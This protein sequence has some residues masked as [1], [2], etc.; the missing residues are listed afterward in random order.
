LAGGIVSLWKTEVSRHA[1][2]R[3]R[4]IRQRAGLSVSNSRKPRFKLKVV[5]GELL[6]LIDREY[7]FVYTHNLGVQSGTAVI[8]DLQ[9]RR[10]FALCNRVLFFITEYPECADSLAIACRRLDRI[11]RN[12]LLSIFDLFEL[13]E[14][15][16][17]IQLYNNVISK[18]NVELSSTSDTA[19]AQLATPNQK[20]RWDGLREAML[21]D[22]KQPFIETVGRNGTSRNSTT[23]H[24]DLSTGDLTQE[25][26]EMRFQAMRD[27]QHPFIAIADSLLLVRPTHSVSTKYEDEVFVRRICLVS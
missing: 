2:S 8:E 7:K 23:N 17:Y 4:P 19:Q 13:Q 18:S 3:S 26:R 15:S 12:R 16:D 27:S 9:A 6:D 14:I 22:T 25:A 1:K 11:S 10:M 20:S 24:G 5:L 21:R